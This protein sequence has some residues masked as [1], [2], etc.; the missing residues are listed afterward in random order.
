MKPVTPDVRKGIWSTLRRTCP[1]GLFSGASILE[2]SGPLPLFVLLFVAALC[3]KADDIAGLLVRASDGDRTIWFEAPTVSFFL[4][5]EQSI[6]AQL[7][8][9]FDAE[10]SGRIKILEAGRY[11]FSSEAKVLV[12]GREV[13]NRPVELQVGTPEIRVRYSRAPGATAQLQLRWES[14]QFPPEPVPGRVLFRESD[15]P[16]LA[17]SKQLEAGRNLITEY[18]CVGCHSTDRPFLKN[19]S[20]P[21]LSFIG[22]RTTPG[23]IFKW[24]E[25]PQHFRASSLMPRISLTRQQ[26]A[27]VAAYLG[28]LKKSGERARSV[29]Q[30][31]TG[32]GEVLFQTVGCAACHNNTNGV[33]LAGI[34]SKYSLAS[35][36]EYLSDPLAVDPS[37]RMPNMLL[38]RAEADALAVHLIGSRN[39]AFEP[40]APRGNSERGR[41][42][43]A[44]RGCLNCHSLAGVVSKLRAPPLR[45]L[46][47]ERSCVAESPPESVPQFAF[48]AHQRA[49]INAWLQRQDISEAPASDAFRIVES[50]NCRKCHEYY[51]PPESTFEASQRPPPLSEAG[52]K[53]RRSWLDQVLNGKKRARPWMSLRMPH[54]GSNN[55]HHLLDYLHAQVGSE[56]GEGEK[57]S[58]PTPEQVA[59]GANLL[60]RGEGGL[61]CINCHDF[62]GQPSGGEMRGPDMTEMDARIRVDWLRRFLHD[63]QRI[64]PSTSMPSYFTGLPRDQAFSQITKIIQGLA[65]GKDM[66]MPS[67][68]A[69]A[70]QP[71]YLLVKDE[72]I[73]F[74]TF[75]EDSSPRS[76]VVGF[77]GL[78]SYV[79]DAQLCRLRYAW[80]GDFLDVKPVWAD[81]GGNQAKILGKKYFNAPETYPIRIGD[82]E[83]VP[84]V[85]FRGYKLIN[86][87]PEFMYQVDGVPVKELIT[88][89]PK[90]L[91]REFT[92]P[93][94][95]AWFVSDPISGVEITTS[96]G[97]LQSGRIKIPPGRF[98]VTITKK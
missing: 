46:R 72:P 41:A 60:G 86:R 12:N 44:Q 29:T 40:P 14:D 21:D 8:P 34:G 25:D 27:D 45:D 88:S 2:W 32:H 81:R 56:P 54:Y 7:K 39:D 15:P 53:L 79:F 63:P 71:F 64:L 36:A 90:G 73:V 70:T 94:K 6:H 61:S 69:E 57:I 11:T 74:R 93:A 5:P 55:V 59:A 4:Q 22:S 26:R 30:A 16:D 1:K 50:L 35:L 87:I 98:E 52:Y 18:N 75:I 58:Q 9:V 10:W 91:L 43:I 97:P 13:Q 48:T 23:W 84:E 62:R 82:P 89:A 51:R 42:L 85:K 47:P 80:S 76:I 92:V 78:N 66:P 24:L 77:P 28:R 68:L 96:A 17:A 31:N 65:G 20:A 37:G 95:D 49:S 83:R 3:A 33:S 67:G 19:R 38:A